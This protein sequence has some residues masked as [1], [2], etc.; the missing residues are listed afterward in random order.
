[1]PRHKAN[2]QRRPNVLGL[3][4]RN[5]NARNIPLQ[6]GS[7]GTG[8]R[9]GRKVTYAYNPHL[10]PACV[11]T[12]GKGDS[13]PELLEKAKHAPLTTRGSDSVGGSAE[14]A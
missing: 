9:S 12:R 4:V 13:L 6:A 7:T 1:M 8:A 2:R 10:P 5:A 3:S 14:A 11:S